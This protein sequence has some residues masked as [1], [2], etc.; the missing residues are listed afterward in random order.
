MKSL[1]KYKRPTNCIRG[2]NYCPQKYNIDPDIFIIRDYPNSIYFNAFDFAV[3]T[4]SYNTFH[5]TIFFGI[6]TILFP[7]KET[8][9][10][11]QHARA[12]I[13]LELKTSF[14]F[15][16]FDTKKIRRGSI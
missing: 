10:D 7:T 8:G 14:V 16:S 11:N 3:V 1:K 13:A 4:G 2:V 9:T 6:P 12:R 5:E 15:H